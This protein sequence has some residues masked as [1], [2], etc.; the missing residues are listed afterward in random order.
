MSFYKNSIFGINRDPCLLPL[1][2]QNCHS[3]FVRTSF[4][5]MGRVC[6]A[7]PGCMGLATSISDMATDLSVSTNAS[8]KRMARAAEKFGCGSFVS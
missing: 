4:Q 7:R 8:L 5:D 1:I 3:G 6:P 2:T